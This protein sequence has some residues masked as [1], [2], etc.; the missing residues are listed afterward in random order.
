MSDLHK[1]DDQQRDG[2]GPVTVVDVG[3]LS[4][5]QLER[6]RA[7][8]AS[9]VDIDPTRGVVR[10]LDDGGDPVVVAG[11]G[12]AKHATLVGEAVVG[13]IEAHLAHAMRLG[14][15]HGA[16]VVSGKGGADGG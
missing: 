11:F 15:A 8:A 2:G 16:A 6:C 1:H 9:V 3:E 5:A 13:H 10:F 12:L 7:M 4:E 14:I